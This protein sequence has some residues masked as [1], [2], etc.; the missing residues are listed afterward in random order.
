MIK[1][2]ETKIKLMGGPSLESR[3]CLTPGWVCQDA[4]SPIPL[5]SLLVAY[6]PLWRALPSADLYHIDGVEQGP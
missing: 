6:S 2:Y 4:L 5:D 3:H 1:N